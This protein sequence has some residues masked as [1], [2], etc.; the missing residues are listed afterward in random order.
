MRHIK[1]TPMFGPGLLRNSSGL[2]VANAVAGFIIVGAI[3][4]RY[5]VICLAIILSMPLP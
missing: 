2:L 1:P 5:L 4:A 3:N